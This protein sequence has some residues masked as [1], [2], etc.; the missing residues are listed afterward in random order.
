MISIRKMLSTT[1]RQPSLFYVALGHQAS[2]IK[3]DLL[4]PVDRLL[5]DPGLVEIVR[6]AQAKR[7]PNSRTTGRYTI[8]P[9]RLVRCCALKHIK[10]WSFR[11][12]ERELRSGLGYRRFTRFDE[13]PIPNFS[14]FSRNFAVLGPEVTERIHAHVVAMARTER[15]ASGQ[16]LRTDT[17][18]VESNVHYPTDSTLLQDGI[19]VLTRSVKRIAN[20]CLDGTVKIVDHG[21][22]VQRRVLEIHRA[23]KSYTEAARGRLEE[24][25]RK[26]V[27][28][29][30][31]VV[32]KA[33]KV[34]EDLSSGSAPIVGSAVSVVANE[35]ALRHYVPLVCAASAG[36]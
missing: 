36:T 20:E 15:V 35:V 31:A 5:D 17:T 1:A 29:A 33:E 28:L 6:E 12:L 22:S 26:L 16:K 30:S 3:D 14:T 8:A 7:S 32:R 25:Y 18:V 24:G 11:E 27:S 19:R 21:R 13:S 2:L 4:D 23:A 10:N 9:D 34:S